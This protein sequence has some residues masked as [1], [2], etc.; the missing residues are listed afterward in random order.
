[1][2]DKEKITMV[3][4]F[5]EIAKLCESMKLPSLNK[6][7]DCWECELD[8][9]WTIIVN[10]HREP[11]MWHDIEIAPFHCYVEYNGWPAGIFSPRGGSIAAGS[12]ANEDKLI[13]AIQLKRLQVVF[14]PEKKGNE[15]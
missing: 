4:V 11:K 12:E 5:V 6:F 8:K 10:G 7:P 9:R 15:K 14:Y 1:M 2:G 3:E 13:K